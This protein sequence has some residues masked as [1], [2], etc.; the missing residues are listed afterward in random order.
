M[1]KT[2][3]NIPQRLCSL[4]G[5]D[6]MPRDTSSLEPCH[7]WTQALEHTESLFATAICSIG[8]TC[9]CPIRQAEPQVVLGCLDT[10]RKDTALSAVGV[11]ASP[12][13]CIR[14]SHGASR[15]RCGHHPFKS[16]VLS[17]HTC[18][19]WCNG[20]QA[21]SAYCWLVRCCG[22]AALDRKPRVLQE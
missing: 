13:A 15:H 9:T 2:N 11:G 19:P 7:T 21:R 12:S 3:G 20:R 1:Q 8:Q 5:F 18:L 22:D 10:L 17:K 16:S 6:Q 14:L 4:K